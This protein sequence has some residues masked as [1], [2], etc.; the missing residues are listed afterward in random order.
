LAIIMAVDLLPTREPMRTPDPPGPR[1][2]PRRF[3]RWSGLK[4]SRWGALALVLALTAVSAL[5]RTRALS[6]HYWVDEGISVGISSHPLGQLPALLRE[7]GS[8]PLYYL[9]LHVW[10]ALWGRG[11]VA[12]HLLSLIFALVTIPVAYWAGASLF[13]RRTGIYCTVLAAAVPYLTTYAQETRMYSLLLLLSLIVAVSFVHVFVFRRRRYLPVFIVSLAAA[14]YTHNWALFLGIAA[15]LAFLLCVR[16]T[17][18]ERRGLWRDGAL[19]FGV[20]AVLY[21]P[22]LPTLLYQARHTGAPWSLPPVI[23]SLPQGLYFIV[24]GRGAA[25]ALLLAAGSG[26]LIL[27]SIGPAGRP[28]RMAAVSLVVLGIGTMIAGWLEAKVTSAWAPRYLAVVVGPMILLA[29]MGLARASRLGLVAAALVCCFWVL[30]PLP[31]SLDSK[32][33]VAAA[34]RVVRAPAGADALV[35]STQPEQVPTLAYYFPRVTRFGTPLGRVPDPRVVDWR[36][37]LEHFRHSSVRTVLVPMLGSL[38]PGERVALVV[39]TQIPKTPDW[40]RLIRRATKS[41]THYLEHDPQLELLKV[42][43]PHAGSSGLPVRISL[44]VVR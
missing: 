2:R 13:G 9:L 33:N 20:V 38:T 27:R 37:A 42:T 22:W 25:V 19:A 8:P 17:P 44:L 39:P 5:L 31:T 21:L 43:S 4:T 36:N 1:V 26:L 7:D 24:G 3:E 32:S 40:M 18:L 41:W 34:A 15:F 30:D 29:G 23:W 28:L 35:L 12:T 10:M 16:A 14:L 11:E 6:F